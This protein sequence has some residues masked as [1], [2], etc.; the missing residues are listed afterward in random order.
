MEMYVGYAWVY[1]TTDNIAVTFTTDCRLQ[2]YEEITLKFE[3]LTANIKT[4]KSTDK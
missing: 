2:R 1:F 4:V 3:H